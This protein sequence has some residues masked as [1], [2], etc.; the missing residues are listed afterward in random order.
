MRL[1]PNVC[2]VLVSRTRNKS[3]ILDAAFGFTGGLGPDEGL[4]VSVP[5]GKEASDDTL[6]LGNFGETAAPNRLLADNAE[7]AL[8]QIEPRGAGRGEVQVKPRRVLKLGFYLGMLVGPVVVA[9]Q[10]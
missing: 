8:D 4:G 6:Q 2:S 7:P 3:S 1:P 5:V 9:D 10:V